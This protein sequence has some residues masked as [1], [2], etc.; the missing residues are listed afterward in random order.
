[1]FCFFSEHKEAELEAI[2]EITAQLNKL[3][4]S[5]GGKFGGGDGERSEASILEKSAAS[6][7]ETRCN[8]CSSNL[9]KRL[10]LRKTAVHQRMA[11]GEA[12]VVTDNA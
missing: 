2:L 1:M 7:A 9:M 12:M 8:A 5:T 11:S 6:L 4:G 3:S 10:L